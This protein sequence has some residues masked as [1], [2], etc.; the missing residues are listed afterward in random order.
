MVLKI[1]PQAT[2]PT[3]DPFDRLLGHFGTWQ[4]IVVVT[5]SLV[6]LSSG[7]VQMAILFLTP[8]VTFWCSNMANSTA[9]ISNTTN[10]TWTGYNNT[11][12]ENCAKYEYDGTP[13]GNTI[14]SEW[15]LVCD[16][17]WLASF[18][19]MMLQLGIL[20]GSIVFGFL[21]DR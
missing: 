10:V 5:I 13:M 4:L 11:C 3:D 8:N 15:D 2:K 7:W 19:Q 1:F 18:T 12:Y 14:I 9:E 6:K 21:S 16:R 17:R 20:I